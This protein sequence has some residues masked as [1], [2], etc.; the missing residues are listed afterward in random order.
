MVGLEENLLAGAKYAAVEQG[1]ED[2]GGCYNSG[3]VIQRVIVDAMRIWSR[4]QLHRQLKDG[5]TSARIEPWAAAEVDGEVAVH[6]RADS[7]EGAHQDVAV[8]LLSNRER[9]LAEYAQG[10]IGIVVRAVGHGGRGVV[11]CHCRPQVVTTGF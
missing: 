6:D 3:V 8:D 1:A 4:N 11:R 9:E 10:W 5:A 7:A 2:E